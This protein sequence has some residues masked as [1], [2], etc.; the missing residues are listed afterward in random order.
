MDRLYFSLGAASGALA[1]AAG[2]FGAHAL[3]ARL[4][5]D[6]LAVFET[7]SRYQMFHALALLAAAWAVSRWPGWRSRTAGLCFIAG[8]VVFCGSLYALTLTGMRALGAITPV[9]GV[10]LI[11]G[12]V[13]LALAPLRR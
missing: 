11:V 13:L 8:S 1:V 2:A 5:A 3:K 9:G 7:A 10:M 4:S 6:L 12:W